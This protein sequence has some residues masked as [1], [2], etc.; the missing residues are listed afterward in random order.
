MTPTA[1]V[2]TGGGGWHLYYRHP[3]GQLLAALPGRAGVDIK[4]DGGY[5]VAPPSAH[6]GTGRAYRWAGGR[7][8]IEMPPA[9]G[10][11]PDPTARGRAAAPA[12]ADPRRRGHL[13][14]PGAAGRPPARSGNRPRRPPPGHLV[15]RRPRGRPHDRCRGHHRGRRPRRADRGRTGRRSD[16]TR[17]PRLPSTA[18]SATKEPPHDH[19]SGRHR[20]RPAVPWRAGTRRARRVRPAQGAR[21]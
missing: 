12:R 17:H 14:T 2:T 3:G 15:R 9:P 8:V 18:H 7:P 13:I 21:T 6:P 11:R 16:R 20:G 5:V 4:A 1:A 10:R 19:R